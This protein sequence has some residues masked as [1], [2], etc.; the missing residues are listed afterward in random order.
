MTLNFEEADESQKQI[1]VIGTGNLFGSR[2]W[3]IL[4]LID[5]FKH[6]IHVCGVTKVGQ[7]MCEGNCTDFQM[8]MVPDGMIQ[9]EYK[10]P[11]AN[12]TFRLN[13]TN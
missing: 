5:F 3:I 7:N 6:R 1:G 10:S 8:T 13:K 11:D 12:G 9:G 2:I 4:R